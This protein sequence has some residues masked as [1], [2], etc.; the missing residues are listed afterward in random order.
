MTRIET[1]KARVNALQEEYEKDMNLLEKA[2]DEGA[3]TVFS[4][5]D[6]TSDIC[7]YDVVCRMIYN[8]VMRDH[9][10]LSRRIEDTYKQIE[11][12]KTIIRTL[13]SKCCFFGNFDLG[14]YNYATDE[15]AKAIE[16]CIVKLYCEKRKVSVYSLGITS[17]TQILISNKKNS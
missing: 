5:I 11:K 9:G 16:D 10:G 13:E 17:Y 1:L 7:T 6:V 12:L 8:Q 3:K 4:M 14:Y 2:I 15:H